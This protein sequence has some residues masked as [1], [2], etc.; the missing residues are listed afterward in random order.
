MLQKTHQIPKLS[1]H[2]KAVRL[3]KN[4]KLIIVG[5]TFILEYRVTK[6][7]QT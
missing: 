5:P 3:E 6:P 4:P 1:K 7:N 2:N